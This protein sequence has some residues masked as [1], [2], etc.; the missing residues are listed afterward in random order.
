MQKLHFKLREYKIIFL[1]SLGGVHKIFRCNQAW[2]SWISNFA[3]EQLLPQLLK[4]TNFIKNGRIKC[5]LKFVNTLEYMDL[6]LQKECH[7]KEKLLNESSAS[8]FAKSYKEK[9]SKARKGGRNVSK[10]TLP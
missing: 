10:S 8:R 7:A 4:G 2:E 1:S 5:G 6:Q 3:W 9:I